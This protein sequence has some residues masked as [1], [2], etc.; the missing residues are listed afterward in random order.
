LRRALAAALL[1]LALGSAC[2]RDEARPSGI[3]ERW[4]QAVSELGRDGLREDAEERLREYG[5]APA[6]E[7]PDAEADERTFSDLEVGK[8]RLQGDIA[9]VPF[10]VNARIEGDRKREIEGALELVKDGDSWSVTQVVPPGPEDRVPSEGGDRPARSKASQWVLALLLGL[11]MTVGAV[12]V[13]ERQPLPE[14]RH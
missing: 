7:V 11:A 2:A 13:I 10:R 14:A 5:T 3:A 6:I 4:L 9:V 1:V 12:L 8:A